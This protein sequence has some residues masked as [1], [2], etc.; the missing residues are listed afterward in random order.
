MFTSIIRALPSSRLKNHVTISFD[1]L[2]AL[3]K[4]ILT[5]DPLR[6]FAPKAGAVGTSDEC[7]GM[8]PPLLARPGN[9]PVFAD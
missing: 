1:I 9:Q 5:R 3:E 8:S 4:R 2:A 6:T 7:G